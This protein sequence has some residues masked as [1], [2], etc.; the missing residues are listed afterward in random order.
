MHKVLYIVLVFIVI[1][2][3]GGCDIFD[4][5]NTSHPNEGGIN[6]VVDWSKTGNQ[7]PSSYQA[8]FIASSGESRVFNLQNNNELLVVMPGEGMLYVY[9]DAENI[10]ISGKKVSVHANHPPELFYSYAGSVFTER[11]KDISHIATMVQQT[12]ELRISFAIKPAAMISQVKSVTAVLEGVYSELDMQTNELSAPTS[13]NVD[14]VKNA[15]HATALVRALGFDPSLKQNLKLVVEFGFGSSTSITYDL[16]SWVSDFN[17]SKDSVL[18]LT[19]DLNVSNASSSSPVVT[20][21]QW[22][23]NEEI[24]YLSLFPSEIEWDHEAF[25]ASIEVVTDQP[26]WAYDVVATNNWLT[27][28]KSDS[29]LVLSANANQSSQKREA[30]IHISAGGLN[31]S[32]TITQNQVLSPY[33]VDKETIKLQSATVGNGVNIIL[34]GDGYTIA[35]MQRGTGKYERDMRTAVDHFFSVYPYSRYKDHFNVYMITAISNQAGISDKTTNTIVDN[36][37]KTVMDGGRSTRIGCNEQMVIE[38]VNAITDLASA[39]LNDLTVIIPINADVYAGTCFMNYYGINMTDFGNGFSI[40]L[41]PVGNDFKKVVMHEA[42]GH[43][44]AKLLDEYYEYYHPNEIF[45]KEDTH[46][47]SGKNTINYFKTTLAWCENVDFYSNITLTSW[48]GFA[49][50]S[51]YNMVGTFEGAY[52]YGK[53]IWRPEYNSCMNNN[54]PY[55]NAPSRWAQVRRIK[56]LAGINYSFSQFLQDDVVPAYPTT[57]RGY[58]AKDF[59]PLAPPVMQVYKE[60]PNDRK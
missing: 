1:F 52:L 27:V 58:D 39:H 15:Y 29:R 14:F 46:E 9:N 6:L 4:H 48:S 26:S 35:D 25:N 47:V 38:Y 43:G 51:K 10:A 40:S 19:A 56:K 24:R 60:V 37:F 12:G 59:V 55:F 49:G 13:I 33:Y 31:E 8:R 23:R 5:D 2:S 34:M 17:Q 42:G 20:V 53:E 22:A 54:V 57:T 21:N 16:A 28:N 11:D 18:S 41:C 7:P 50:L 44:F 45:P 32:V 30:T 3:I 36:K